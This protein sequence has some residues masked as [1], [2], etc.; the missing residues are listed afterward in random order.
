MVNPVRSGFSG[1]PNRL[2]IREFANSRGAEFS[3]KAGAFYA[4]KL[5]VGNRPRIFDSC[6]LRK[7]FGYVFISKSLQPYFSGRG[8]FRKGLWDSRG[9]CP[10]LRKTYPEITGSK[11]GARTIQQS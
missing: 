2:R 4:A 9:K 10:N 8:V 1:N 6:V 7:R 11:E 5:D 3:T